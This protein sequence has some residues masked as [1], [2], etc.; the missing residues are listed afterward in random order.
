M[1]R[2][3]IPAVFA[4]QLFA[5]M[6]MAQSWYD[7]YDAGLDAA[8]RGDWQTV[9]QKMNAAIK[10]NPKEDNR[11]REYGTIFINYH[12]YYYR[13]VAYLNTGKYQEAISD[14]EKTMGPGEENLGSI[15]SLIDRAKARLAAANTP[16]PQ[17]A[18]PQP[19][20]PAPQ[21]AMPQPVAPTIDPALRQRAQAA[22]NDAKQH[23][24]QAQKR[25]ATQ[26]PQ[27]SQAL[28]AIAQANTKSAEAHTNDD[29]NAAIAAAENA[30]IY[31][32]AAAAPGIPTSPQPVPRPTAAARTV[33]NDTTQRVRLALESYFNGDFDDA[34]TRFDQLSH[35]MPQNGWIWA[36]LGASQYSQYAF[37]ADDSY[38]DAA[39]QSFRKAK[40]LRQ[41][42]D[43]LPSKYFSKRIRKVFDNAG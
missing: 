34:A 21:P 4:L 41:F 15:E 7:N 37:E 3:I 27:Y 13:A 39:M 25:N 16:P 6:A 23:I 43:G 12:P 11:A 19:V 33:V 18:T 20:R 29:L 14:L 22:I 38:R 30:S 8:R 28:Q 35:E 31:A 24:A 36:F 32:D 17:P 2:K 40:Q 1:I 9:V 10:E 5:G 42:K 26:S